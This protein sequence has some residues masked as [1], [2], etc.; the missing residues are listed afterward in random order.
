MTWILRSPLHGMIS[1][2][3]MVLTYTGRK[4]GRQI[5]LPVGY[6]QMDG[7]LLNTSLR[8]RTWWRSLRGGA[9]VRLHLRGRARPAQA[10]A[11]DTGEEIRQGFLS[12]FA[13]SPGAM[14]VFGVRPGPDGQ[15]SEPDLQ[16]LAAE[17]VVIYYTLQDE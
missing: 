9:P 5:S 1:S 16:R 7:R 4:T 14:R 11:F 3:M 8:S 12:Y 15:P 2:G 6:I 17:R 13:R 10:E